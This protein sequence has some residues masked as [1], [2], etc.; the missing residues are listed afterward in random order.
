MARTE[1]NTR[2][3]LLEV[4]EAR[5]KSQMADSRSAKPY[6][7]WDIP[8]LHRWETIRGNSCPSAGSVSISR[9]SRSITWCASPSTSSCSERSLMSASEMRPVYMY[10]RA[11]DGAVEQCQSCSCSRHRR[12]S[13]G[14]YS[15]EYEYE[16]E[17]I[18]NQVPEGGRSGVLQLDLS[19]R[20]LAH[21]AIKQRSANAF[22]QNNYS[23]NWILC[24]VLC[25]VHVRVLRSRSKH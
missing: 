19:A 15:L 16:Y 5:R 13:I 1:S 2:H 17:C 7:T 24:T 6:Y 12:T 3:T 18:L 8:V 10:L 22:N 4:S 21:P 14:S 20:T 23:L 11:T 25:T 9:Q